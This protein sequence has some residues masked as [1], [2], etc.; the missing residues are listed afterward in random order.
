MDTLPDTGIIFYIVRES[1]ESSANEP[2]LI[3]NCG[4]DPSEAWDR[5]YSLFTRPFDE[6][7][8]RIRTLLECTVEAKVTRTYSTTSY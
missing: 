4:S 5:A 6:D 1:A 3:V 7:T 8:N 2:D